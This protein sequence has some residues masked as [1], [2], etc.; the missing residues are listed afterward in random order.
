M[1]K[2]LRIKVRRVMDSEIKARQIGRWTVQERLP[3]G[4]GPHPVMLLAHGLTGD[5][6]VMWVFTRRLSQEYLMIAPRGL[7][8]VMLGGYGWHGSIDRP[9]PTWQDL[10]PAVEDLLELLSTANFPQADFSRMHAMG[11]S[12]GAALLYT[13]ALLNPERVQ[14][15]A[16][17]SGFMPE[18]AGELIARRPLEGKP[19]FLAH[20]TKDELVPV[21]KARQAV[22]LLEQ[23]GAA[24]TYCE[25]EVGHKLSLPCFRGMEKFFATQSIS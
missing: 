2:Q 10:Q 1:Q 22:E 17:L 15:L 11:F 6:S 16:G 25:E 21:D 12:Q 4:P 14:A 7:H 24:V 19:V 18:E 20:G 13:L 23:A 9:W 3:A 8:P 5:E